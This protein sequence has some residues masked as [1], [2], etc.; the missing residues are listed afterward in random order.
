MITVAGKPIIERIMDHYASY[1]FTN[2]VVLGGY[3]Y[4]VIRNFF[5]DFDKYNVEVIDTG[6][7]T[8]TGGRLKYLNGLVDGDFF[9]TYGDGLCD[10]N[11]LELLDFHKH[12]KKILTLTAIRPKSKYGLLEFDG[13]KIISFSEKSQISNWI[14]GGFFV[15]NKSILDYV[16]SSETIF[17][18]GV[19]SKL[20]ALNE[21]IGFKFDGFWRSMDDENE[22]IELDK[23]YLKE[24]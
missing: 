17:E 16:N 24:I 22:K 20:L 23:L 2:F 11:I 14:N 1:G 18:S 5:S 3:K 4:N 9:L 8:M 10:V 21:V 7:E 19:I 6:I 12:N 15:C 13:D